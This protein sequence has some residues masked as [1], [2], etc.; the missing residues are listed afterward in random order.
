MAIGKILQSGDASLRF[1]DALFK[2]E[3]CVAARQRSFLE[4]LLARDRAEK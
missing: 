2:G 3:V 4:I 1:W